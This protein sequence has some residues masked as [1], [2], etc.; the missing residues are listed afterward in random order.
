MNLV[1]YLQPVSILIEVIICGI[2]VGIGVLK[3]KTFG[4]LIAFTFAMYTIYDISGYTG[5]GLSPDVSSIIF[6]AA[7]ISML[8]AVW[9]LFSRE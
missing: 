7:S 2:G 9:I 5:S 1:V 8:S 6:L 4:W 3:K